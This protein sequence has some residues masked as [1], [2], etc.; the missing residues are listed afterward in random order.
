[1]VLCRFLLLP[2]MH[3]QKRGAC[4]CTLHE[5]PGRMV[6]S[7]IHRKEMQKH[8]A[9]SPYTAD[10]K[11]QVAG[12][13][14]KL[15]LPSSIQPRDS[16]QSRPAAGAHFPAVSTHLSE[17]SFALSLKSDVFT[18]SLSFSMINSI[19]KYNG[20]HYK[21]VTKAFCSFELS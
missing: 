20:T 1:M 3:P 5:N 6:P 15:L 14:G 2:F 19:T 18:L 16:S 13:A 4:G 11:E 21:Y 7:V 9:K 10:R 8:S 17:N 12:P